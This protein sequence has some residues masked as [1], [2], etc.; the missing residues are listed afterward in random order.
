M[1]TDL[2]VSFF[3]AIRLLKRS[4]KAGTF[5]TIFIIALVFTNMIFMSSIISGSIYLYND[6]TVNYYVSDIIIKPSGDD[7]YIEKVPGLLEKINRVR[8]VQRAS[9]RYELGASLRHKSKE[10][11]LPVIAVE[12]EDEIQVM[13]IATK[14]RSGEY[15]GRG[16]RNEILIGNFVAGNVDESM[17]LFESLGGVKVGDLITV[18]YVN[19]VSKPYRVKGIFQTKS[20]QADYMVFVSWDEME[21]VMGSPVDQASEILVRTRPGSDIN[22]VKVELLQNGVSEKVKTWKEQTGKA[23]GEAIESFDIINNITIIVSLIIAVVVLFIIIMIKTLHNRKEIGI[24]KAIGIDRSII[25]LSYVIQTVIIAV[26]GIILGFFI[27]QGL[28][29]WFTAYP[30][31]FPNGNITPHID[32]YLLIESAMMLLV[33]SAIAGFLPAWRIV[34]ED[35]LKSIRG[36]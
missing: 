23:V 7:R 31:E 32:R 17:D 22:R 14:M 18:S 20:Y 33:A 15:L 29:A 13:R 8:G 2:K 28:S 34:R 10:I 27:L 30:I 25:V 11:S 21:D 36:V 6:Q 16:D 3:L 26:I 19:G 35:I 9:A 4:S 1:L 24:L 5:L 12:P